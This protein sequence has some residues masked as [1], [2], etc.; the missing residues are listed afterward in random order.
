MTM[1]RTMLV[2]SLLWLAGNATRL[3]ILAVPPVLPM[4]RSDLGLSETAVGIV[5]GLP[6]VLF[7]LAAVPGSLLIA[8][9]GA[10]R[11]LIAGLL[12][13]AAATVLRSASPDALV[14]DLT[15]IGVAAGIAIMHVALPPLV[16]EWLPQRIPL[17]TAVYTNGLLIGEILPVMLM[18]PVVLP[19]AGG[20]WRVG[21]AIW[22]APLALIA[23]AIAA[24]APR[25][26]PGPA[27][28][29]AAPR[30][31][32]PDWRNGTVWRLGLMFGSVNSMYFATNAFLP[33]YMH[34]LG[35]PDLVSAA[36]TALNLGQLPASLLLLAVAARLE[37]RI[38]PLLAAAVLCLIGYAGILSGSAVWVIAGC[39][40]IG[41]AASGVFVLILALPPRLSAPDDVHRVSA[42]I[43]TISYS[44]GVIVPIL[45]GIAWDM[46]HAP[47]VA[48]VPTALCSLLLA[49]VASTLDFHDRKVW[50]DAKTD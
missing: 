38:W 40:L 27:R 14:L 4:M 45:S 33:D 11:T 21:L 34:T 32:W 35:R 50:Y 25:P 42:A 22:A 29:A 37:R 2:L 36:L 20:N 24:L 9:F 18:L 30:R 39:G 16:R 6:P 23:V 41:F 13:G 3:P 5:S 31:W 15:T 26:P 12:A 8:W 43:F 44:C 1:R 10:R 19:L 17:A 48:F 28:T 49:G 7:A 47:G 46:T